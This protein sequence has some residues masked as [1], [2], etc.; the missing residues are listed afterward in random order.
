MAPAERQTS[1]PSRLS[2]IQLCLIVWPQLVNIYLEQTQSNNCSSPAHKEV[3]T[4]ARASAE[5][6][7]IKGGSERKN[8]WE[9]KSCGIQG[10]MASEQALLVLW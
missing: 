8:K 2:S 4:K 9:N 5:I 7:A 10:R 6:R 1:Q 3:N